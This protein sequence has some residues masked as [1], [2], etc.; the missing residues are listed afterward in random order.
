YNVLIYV[1]TPGIDPLFFTA[2]NWTPDGH[3]Y[4]SIPANQW[5]TIEGWKDIT[6]YANWTG[7]ITKYESLSMTVSVRLTQSPS[8][9]RLGVSP[10]STPY[11]EILTFTIIYWDEANNTGI[12]NATGPYAHNVSI[13]VIVETLGHQL[14]QSVMTIIELG[15]GEYQIS[16]STFYI[17]GLSSCNLRIYANWT[18]DAL[19]LYENSTLLVAVETV[20]RQTIVE[21]TPMPVTAYDA[22]VNLT[23]FFK[24]VTTGSAIEN[25]LNLYVSIAESGVF[26]TLYYDSATREFTIAIDTTGWAMPGSFTF[27]L[28]VTWTGVPYYQNRTSV[29][30]PI[31]I[32][33]RYTDLTHGSISP[34][35]FEESLT[36]IFTFRDTDDLSL[37]N[38]GDLT[39]DA[40]L[41]GHYTSFNNGNGTYTVELDSDVFSST[42][43]Y[44]VNVSLQYTGSRFREDGTDFFYF[45]I[46]SRRTVLTSELPQSAPFLTIAE[47]NVTYSDDTSSIG[48]DGADIFAFC[49]NAT[50]LLVKDTNYWIVSHGSGVYEVQISTEA[51]GNFGFYSVLVTANY[52][53]GDTFYSERTRYVGITVIR[54]T[55]SLSVSRSPVSTPFMENVTF[56]IRLVDAVTLLG[57]EINKT[58]LVL[59]HG[60]GIPIL[61][62]QFMITNISSESYEISIDSTVLTSQL[63]NEY[64]IYIQFFWGDSEPFYGNVTSSTKV[65][66]KTRDTQASVLSTPPAYY[67]FDLTA[68]LRYSDYLSSGPI[69]GADI[70]LVCL[71][72]STIIY[73][74]DDNADGTYTIYV[75]TTSLDSLG[76]YFFEANITWTGSPFYTN[77][78]AIPFSVNVNP[79]ST[80]LSFNLPEDATYY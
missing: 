10:T 4:I 52:S 47:F 62:S 9:L 46:I 61:S 35:Q 38:T 13:Y 22:A 55:A 29:E 79:V 39:L 14:N 3:Y 34:V 11:G 48:I 28:N 51:L 16:F 7:T 73:S 67:F 8:D 75:D 6:V 26:V 37:I 23:F 65:T 71:N 42:G 24:D 76:R 58:H 2:A 59:T 74:F 63:T 80:T 20:Y 66:V 72:D 19:P 50:D 17:S 77:Q 5:D 49:I 21:W 25:D 15:N 70:T 33:N 27:H 45:T 32:R 60:A 64:P 43:V 36:I 1:T 30:I 40:W 44:L 53:I 41:F 68:I 56:D 18:K 31:T 54:R 69:I 78:T 57:I 12:V